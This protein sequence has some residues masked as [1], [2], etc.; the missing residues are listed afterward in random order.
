MSALFGHRSLDAPGSPRTIL[1]C[2]PNDQRCNLCH[3]A[4]PTWRSEPTAGH[5][6]G[7]ELRGLVPSGKARLVQILLYEN[8]S[9]RT[10][11]FRSSRCYQIETYLSS[12][13]STC[14]HF[15][16]L[17]YHSGTINRLETLPGTV[18]IDSFRRAYEKES[19]TAHRGNASALASAR[20]ETELRGHERTSTA[21]VVE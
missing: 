10:G 17:L 2:H 18:R 11:S 12:L 21:R 7:P 9:P 3:G 6:I 4:R 5:A 8:N 20:S 1:L 15:S 13:A 19:R 14:G 16:N